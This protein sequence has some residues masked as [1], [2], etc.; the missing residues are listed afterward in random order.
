MSGEAAGAGGRRVHLVDGTFELF[1]AHHSKRPDHRAPSGLPAKATVGL[2]GS[3]LGLLHDEREAVTHLA[4]AFDNPIRSFRNDLWPGYKTEEGVPSELLAQFDAAEEAT[5][6]LGATVWSM[7]EFEADDA[8][9]TGAA[10]FQGQVDQVR[11]LSPDKDLGQCLDGRRVVQVDRMRGREIDEEA[12]LVRRGIRPQSVPDWL[13]LVGDEADGI[14]GLSGF[15]EKTASA[16]L[17]RHLHLEKIP[18]D[19]AR[20]PESIR[21][22]AQLAR[23]LQDAREEALLYR[24]L[25]TLVRDVPLP[26]SLD[27][28]RWRG[29]PRQR[30]ER[31]CESLGVRWPLGAPGAERVRWAE[32]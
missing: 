25:A 21:G 31:W 10:R 28:L 1:R 2:A 15:G 3:L 12:L 16:L 8:L 18:A 6:A 23:S 14:P 9:A 17:G 5:R 29:V 7:R 22:A 20:W 11:I 30:F 32:A 27:D 4:V 13:A 19:P 26:E 24:R